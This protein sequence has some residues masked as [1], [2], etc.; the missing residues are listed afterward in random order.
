NASIEAARAGDAGKGFAVVANEVG[1]LATESATAAEQITESIHNMD[2]ITNT[3][4]EE[5]I[6][7]LNKIKT[8]LSMSNEAKV[9]IDEM[10]KEIF[11]VSTELE[12]VQGDLEEVEQ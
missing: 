8:T 5:F 4:S 7:I 11:E 10:M 6:Q 1:K 2:S 9:S 3:A 12:E